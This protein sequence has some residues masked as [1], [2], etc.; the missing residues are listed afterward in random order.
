MEAIKL[1]IERGLNDFRQAI[2]ETKNPIRIWSCC[3]EN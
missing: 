1:H 3:I 2:E